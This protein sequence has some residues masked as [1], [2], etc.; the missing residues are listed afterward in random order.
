[1]LL[2]E[3]ISSQ[4]VCIDSISLSKTAVLL[5]A[6]Q[7]LSHSQPAL[8]PQFLFDAFWKREA[9]GSTTIGHG[10]TIPHV[11]S[12]LI[13]EP[14]GCFMRLQNPVDFGAEDKQP[15]DLVL[16]FI[17]PSHETEQHLMI[18]SAIMK[19][20]DDHQ[21]REDCRKA[22]SDEDLYRIMIAHQIN[23]SAIEYA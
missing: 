14:T 13:N 12:D 20:F 4:K 22:S 17:V 18:L 6:S 23:S 21:F 9:L 19:K 10:I 11:R 16:A 3:F 2:T 7:L 15:V 1:M 8:D 5:H